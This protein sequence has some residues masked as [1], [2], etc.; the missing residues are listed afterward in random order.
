MY[1]YDAW[2]VLS[3]RFMIYHVCPDIACILH[4]NSLQCISMKYYESIIPLWT[5]NILVN[6]LILA[7]DVCP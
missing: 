7:Y 5:V 1:Q 3:Y 2:C 4:F 6:T